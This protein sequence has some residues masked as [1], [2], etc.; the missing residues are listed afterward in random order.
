M[1]RSVYI[2]FM[3]KELLLEG[4]FFPGTRPLFELDRIY[5]MGGDDI[6]E[7]LRYLYLPPRLGS[8]PVEKHLSILAAE[9]LSDADIPPI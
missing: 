5:Y 9:K 6:T 4:D 1:R 7:V 3:G 8:E 2:N